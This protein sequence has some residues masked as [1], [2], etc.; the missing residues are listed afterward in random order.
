MPRNSSGA[1][2]LPAGNPVQTNTLIEASWANPT[3]SDL[4]SA[5]TD[6]LDRYGRGGMLAEFKVADGSVTAPGLAFTAQTNT[7]MYRV[8]T[9]QL[10]L[11]AG[12]IAVAKFS[13]DGIDLLAPITMG[14]DKRL[15]LADG[16]AAAPALGFASEAGMGLF[17]EAAGALSV[18]VGGVKQA[19]FGLDGVTT[20]KLTAD[21]VTS[22]GAVKAIDAVYVNQLTSGAWTGIVGQKNGVRRWMLRFAD[23]SVDGAGDTGSDFSIL[24][25]DN[26]GNVIAGAAPLVITRATGKT[27]LQAVDVYG[28]LTLP[29]ASTTLAIAVNAT[30]SYVQTYGATYGTT[31]K[32]INIGASEVNLYAI[33]ARAW[34]Q[35]N[36]TFTAPSFALDGDTFWAQDATNI[37]FQMNPQW[38]WRY[39]QASGDLVWMRGNGKNT[40]FSP[41]GDF[42]AGNNIY[43]GNSG[44]PALVSGADPYIGFNSD[45][46]R[47]QFVGSS[48][49]LMYLSSAGQNLF[50]IDGS[51]NIGAKN[52]V[53][54]GNAGQYQFTGS[55][56]YFAKGGISIA[57]YTYSGGLY[58]A[59]ALSSSPGGM[60][61]IVSFQHYPGSYAYIH[62]IVGAGLFYFKSDNV[63]QKGGTDVF[64][65]TASSRHLK[66]DIEDYED[67]LKEVLAIRPRRFRLKS[68]PD[69]EGVGIIADE[70][71]KAL[72]RAIVY[73]KGQDMD[74][75]HATPVFWALVNSVK[76]LTARITTLEKRKARNDH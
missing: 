64:W 19:S 25:G 31:F 23:E 42:H 39:T 35:Q 29:S 17:R 45:A 66:Q 13:P 12:G 5:V 8:A 67:G 1:Y 10:G 47:L 71:K 9:N 56:T 18:A 74:L 44:F 34:L 38:Y 16:T 48:G 40:L 51:G 2:I 72:P 76:E 3:L 27:S 4:A 36:G 24:R 52:Y 68:A 49:Q 41:N 22:L 70:M 26:A 73:D 62:L 61:Q 33:S 20:S 43:C 69:T 59:H 57:D 28:T 7:G 6:S 32:P 14:S 15:L 65:V 75:F 21:S 53:Y 46:W 63:A 37:Y 30:A 58:F 60:Q 50:Y 55:T 11:A 54:A